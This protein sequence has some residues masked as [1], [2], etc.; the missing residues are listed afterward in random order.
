VHQFIADQ[1]P[2]LV[3][4]ASTLVADYLKNP[5][6]AIGTVRGGPWHHR[7]KVLLVG[8]A[9]HA[10]VPFFGQG[11][12]ASLEDCVVLDE[13][14]AQHDDD[15]SK[16]TGDF[17]ERRRPNTDAVADLAMYNYEEIQSRVNDS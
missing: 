12:N 11:M 1:F 6:G 3:P 17:Y 8:D 13:L 15:W 16:V 7:D 4:A 9:A 10:I 14:L 2:D 5:I